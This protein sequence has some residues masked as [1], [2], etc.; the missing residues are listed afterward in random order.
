MKDFTYLLEKNSLDDYNYS[1]EWRIEADKLLAENYTADSVN[2]YIQRVSTLKN[3]ENDKV[4]YIYNCLQMIKQLDDTVK[5]LSD[6][7]DR[8]ELDKEFNDSLMQFSRKEEE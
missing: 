5:V 3:I 1:D 2:E 8:L 4:H 6:K 7:V